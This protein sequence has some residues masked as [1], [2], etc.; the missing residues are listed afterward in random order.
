V[1]PQ[2]WQADLIETSRR[3]AKPG[4]CARCGAAVLRGP[5]ADMA[6]IPV[7]VDASPVGRDA[8]PGDY[9]MFNGELHHLDATPPGRQVWQRHGCPEA[10]R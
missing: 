9:A 1:T 7:V 5:D 4:Q 10:G 6:A 2:P 8:R 3:K